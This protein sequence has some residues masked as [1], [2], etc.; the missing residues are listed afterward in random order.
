MATKKKFLG[1]NGLDANNQTISNVATPSA[2]SDASTKGYADTLVPSQ[3]G[4]T[5]K[6]LTTNGSATSW[7]TVTASASAEAL[8]GT[9]IA[10][11]VTGS[12]LTSV[13]TL[14]SLTVSG[15][16]TFDT[17]TLFVDATNDRVGVGTVSPSYKL[18]VR[19]MARIQSS[20]GYN[21]LFETWNTNE[22]VNFMNDAGSAN[23]SAVFRATDYAWQNGGGSDILKLDSS[24]NLGV[25][26]S[27]P[28]AK[29]TVSGTGTG[30]AIDFTNTTASTGRSYRWVSINSGGFAIE[31]MSASGTERLRITSGLSLIHI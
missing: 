8:T 13:G 19:G 14:G 6:Y 17:N 27:S 26:T 28:T 4:H 30:S 9:T 10:S 12:S 20:S 21:V 15:N 7:A 23:I 22:R 3:S 2:S 24:G 31:D 5:G 11:T 1:N 25:G 29:I 16:A 18:D